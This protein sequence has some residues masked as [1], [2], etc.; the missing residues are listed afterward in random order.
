MTC[1]ISKNYA[2]KVFST[3]DNEEKVVCKIKD[4]S[5]NYTA[6][7]LVNFDTIK[8][9][10]LVTSATPVCVASRNILRTKEQEVITVRQTKLYKPLSV[11]RRFMNDHTTCM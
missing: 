2:Y 8:D 3:R 1:R 5:L 4:I 10:V 7:R 9:M 6:S 11:N